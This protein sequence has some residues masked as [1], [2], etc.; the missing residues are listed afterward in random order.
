M[1]SSLSWVAASLKFADPADH[2]RARAAR[3]DEHVLGVPVAHVDLQSGEPLGQP[4]VER[5]LAQV[6][7]DGEHC[8]SGR[9]M[10]SSTT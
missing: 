7:P 2:Q 9:F 3:V 10:P 4:A 1:F 6:R 5:T 8:C